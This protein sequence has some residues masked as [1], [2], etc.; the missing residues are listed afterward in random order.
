MFKNR[1]HGTEHPGLVEGSMP[2]AGSLELGDFKVPSY[3]KYSMILYK[4][5]LLQT[6]S[7]PCGCPFLCYFTL[8]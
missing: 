3:S 4:E 2:T 7:Q 5:M 6:T 1:L 8:L